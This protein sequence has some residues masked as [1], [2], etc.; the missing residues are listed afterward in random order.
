MRK[1]PNFKS[2]L[3]PGKTKKGLDG[4][5]WVSNMVNGRYRWQ[6][7]PTKAKKPK[8]FNYI[9]D[10]YG[11]ISRN[12]WDP[13]NTDVTPPMDL[14]E[15]VKTQDIP[16]FIQF[17]KNLRVEITKHKALRHG[18]P[19]HGE[20][21]HLH[22]NPSVF[23][24]LEQHLEQKCSEATGGAAVKPAAVA[25][26]CAYLYYINDDI[27]AVDFP[28]P[29]RDH[30]GDKLIYDYLKKTW[31]VTENEVRLYDIEEDLGLSPPYYYT[32]LQRLIE[33]IR[34]ERTLESGVDTFYALPQPEQKKLNALY[35]NYQDGRIRVLRRALKNCEKY[36]AEKRTQ[37]RNESKIILANRVVGRRGSSTDALTNSLREIK[38]TQSVSHP[39]KRR[40]TTIGTIDTKGQSREERT[41][42][43]KYERRKL[44]NHQRNPTT[45]KTIKKE[46][47]TKKALTNFRKQEK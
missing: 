20:Y 37:S 5:M 25:M 14:N 30:D 29:I 9:K 3:V 4:K 11:Q 31:N 45:T 16:R 21:E 18:K 40:R 46:H 38:Y 36:L 39:R 22:Q 27:Y 17:I 28:F 35:L 24:I 43:I 19:T 47:S 41:R 33:C 32:A 10:K 12:S 8:N 6:R 7:K 44:T 42:T 23:Q 1:C 2:S 15:K 34:A 26:R 13:Y